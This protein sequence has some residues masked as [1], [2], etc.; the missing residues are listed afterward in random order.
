MLLWKSLGEMRLSRESLARMSC[1]SSCNGK[2][3]DIGGGILKA[4]AIFA[5]KRMMFVR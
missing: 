3:R 1:N 5:P 4:V 2:R